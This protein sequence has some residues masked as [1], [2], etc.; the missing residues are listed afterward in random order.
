MKS[1]TPLGELI[2]PKDEATSGFLPPGVDFGLRE[3]YFD[4]A[5]GSWSLKV[6]EL[7]H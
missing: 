3:Q 1:L 2:I 4:H 7:K 5:A 6:I